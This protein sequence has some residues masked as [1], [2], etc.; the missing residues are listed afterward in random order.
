MMTLNEPGPCSSR[1]GEPSLI[2]PRS[3]PNSRAISVSACRW[4]P[5]RHVF[6][7]GDIAQIVADRR[8]G[9]TTVLHVV[10]ILDLRARI[11]REMTESHVLLAAP[12]LAPPA[13]DA[14][15]TSRLP[16]SGTTSPT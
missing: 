3:L 5:R 9:N 10:E 2:A 14:W 8:L 1:D 16:A 12:G 7:A 13:R 11:L 4:R 6:V 15:S